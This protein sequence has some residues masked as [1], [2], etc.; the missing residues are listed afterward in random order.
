[1]IVAASVLVVLIFVVGLPAVAPLL[2]AGGEAIGTMLCDA[3]G[4]YAAETCLMTAA[5]AVTAFLDANSVLAA[6]GILTGLS[7][8]CS[9]EAAQIGL[10]L[11]NGDYDQPP[12]PKVIEL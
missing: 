11:G 10:A 8:A 4:T 12:S 7:V 2:V 1:L 5:N 3:A 6:Q 9:I